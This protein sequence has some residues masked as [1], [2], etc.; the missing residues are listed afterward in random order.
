MTRV[1]PDSSRTRIIASASLC[2]SGSSRCAGRTTT[3]R[4]FD[5]DIS[6]LLRV[7]LSGRCAVLPDYDRMGHLLQLFQIMQ[8][9]PLEVGHDRTAHS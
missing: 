7:G 1:R 9:E 5:V 4:L 3:S 6:W 2:R 8:M